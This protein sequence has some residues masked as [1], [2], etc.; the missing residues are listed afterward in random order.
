[1]TVQA[2]L[3]RKTLGGPGMWAFGS[4]ASAPMVV[5]VGGIV[6][7]YAGTGVTGVP[8]AF[9]LVAGVIALLSVGYTAMARHVP[10]AAVYYAVL[11]RGLGREVGVAGGAVALLGYNSI[12]I[13]L[14]GLLGF[15]LSGSFGG[16]WWV[17]A[18]MAVLLVGVLG[19]RNVALSARLLGTVLALSLVVVVLF[20][21]AAF[22]HP[23]T[24]SISLEG[25][26][27]SSLTVP[28][29]G[30][31]FALCLAA[32]MGFEITASFSEEAR[33]EASVK[34][35]VFAA[36]GFLGVLYAIA[37]WAMEVATGPAKVQEVAQDPQGG[38]P[39][40]VLENYGQVTPLL[41]QVVLIGAI[42][43]SL[44]AFHATVARYSFA[45][46]REG[47]LP[48][49]LTRTG[50]GAGAGS[51]IGGSLFQSITAVVVVAAFAV[52]GADPFALLFT[53][54]ST[55]GALSLL[56]L[57]LAASVAAVAYFAGRRGDESV[58]TRVLAPVLG[59]ILG[60]GILLAMLLNV[61]TLLGF[62]PEDDSPL[63]YIIPG[64]VVLTAIVGLIWGVRLR[65]SRP[66]VFSGISQ[67]RPDP[68]AVP[69]PRLSDI[70]V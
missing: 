42:L 46:A 45:M 51:P 9:L 20:D 5:L 55:L 21:I 6:A 53:W 56:V 67:G 48:A 33:S 69:E 59:V 61:G 49:A 4:A 39:F 50:S 26:A 68:L 38:L 30:G 25:F 44:L 28:G 64:V 66:H 43:T 37:A 35:A 29:V 11:A 7:T 19:I 54:L 36:V 65:A 18:F 17:W 62:K 15:I 1:M 3:A 70:D 57:L 8:L 41:G 2:A 22:S 34:R 16:P 13:S 27:L 52:A 58:W 14:Y 40:S 60:L 24:G 12:Q 31:A 10:H 47:V 63:P 32:L 23:A